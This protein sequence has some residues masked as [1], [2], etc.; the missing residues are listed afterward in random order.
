MK[1]FIYLAASAIA[2]GLQFSAYGARETRQSMTPPKWD[3]VETTL[4]VKGRYLI[5]PGGYEANCL[6]CHGPAGHSI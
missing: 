5:V 3:I 1:L 2:L 4:S 6:P